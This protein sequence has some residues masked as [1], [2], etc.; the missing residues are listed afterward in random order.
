V[1]DKKEEEEE[2]EEEEEVTGVRA[3][4]PKAPS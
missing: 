4:L 3:G 2:E 1:E